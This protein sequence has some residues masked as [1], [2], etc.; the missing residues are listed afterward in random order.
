M[1][2]LSQKDLGPLLTDGA[3]D[4]NIVGG[5]S[6]VHDVHHLSSEGQ[7][8]SRQ[9]IGAHARTQ[10]VHPYWQ[11]FGNNGTTQPYVSPLLRPSYVTLLP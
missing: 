4:R 11:H 1:T 5:A 8:A 10:G 6:G 3:N 7:G 2:H 9:K